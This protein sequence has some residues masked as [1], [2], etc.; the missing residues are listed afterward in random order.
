MTCDHMSGWT[1]LATVGEVLGTFVGVAFI[2][3]LVALF[4]RMINAGFR[5]AWREL[6]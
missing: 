5:I 4:L 3:A 1:V 2:V 6:S